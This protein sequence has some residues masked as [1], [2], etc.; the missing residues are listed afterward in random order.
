M[1]PS[2]IL[3][4]PDEFWLFMIGYAFLGLGMGLL[5]IPVI[6]EVI[7]SIY[8]KEG[9]IEGEDEYVDGIISD[10]AAGLYGAFLSFG[11]I[12][13]PI[14]GSTLYSIVG[15]FNKTCDYF[16]YVSITYTF[17]YLIFNVIPDIRKD[18]KE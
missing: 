9:L 10:K 1:G 11:I 8:L 12:I 17:I 4:L 16:G 3:H 14:L 15:N 7:D 2:Y 6:P 5:F 18:K 13:S